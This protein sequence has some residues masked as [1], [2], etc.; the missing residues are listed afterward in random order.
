MLD[1]LALFAGAGGGILGGKLL[2]WRTRCAV[3]IDAYCRK[4]LLQRQ[5]DG[6]LDKFP[7]WDDIKTFD[8]KPWRGHIDVISGGFPCQD[9]SCAGKQKGIHGKRSS[10]WFEM[11]R[12]IGD[13]RPRFV[14]VENTPNLI[15]RGLSEVLGSLASMGYHARWCVLG[16]RHVGAPHKRDRLWLLADSNEFPIWHKQKSKPWGKGQTIVGDHGKK[17]SVA[18]TDC[19]W[20][21]QPQRSIEKKRG[22]TGN[23]CQ[24]IFN[25]NLQRCKEQRKCIAT[26]AQYPTIKCTNWWS[27]EPRLGRVADGVADRVD[28]LKAIGNGQVPA[29]VRL[30]WN[31]LAKGE[32]T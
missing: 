28:R 17:E 21:Q 15:V 18:H 16:A 6:I 4:V 32:T 5:R 11:A 26:E 24:E 14:F 31:T 23:I 27:T 3:E 30:A 13:I 9:I 19:S 8:G 20:E 7:I 25:P 29:V 12:V 1:E 2:G 22:W 10:L